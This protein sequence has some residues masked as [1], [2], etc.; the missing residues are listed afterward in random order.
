MPKLLE[1]D[2]PDTSAEDS[3]GG[4]GVPEVGGPGG[5]VPGRPSGDAA[6]G[7]SPESDGDSAAPKDCVPKFRSDLNYRLVKN[8]LK[9]LPDIDTSD[10]GGLGYTG[11]ALQR[12]R[13]A[14]G[15]L[16]RILTRAAEAHSRCKQAFRASRRRLRMEID[17]AMRDPENKEAN[18]RKD[19]SWRTKGERQ[20][21][22]EAQN[23]RMRE[24]VDQLEDW[25][26]QWGAFKEVVEAGLDRVLHYRQDIG[27][28]LKVLALQRGGED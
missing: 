13:E 6:D 5:D 28:Y 18:E 3:G 17:R 22:V 8:I 4:G 9:T 10:A 25:K 21:I 11:L 20:E 27:K 15:L 2:D 14:E 24:E 19:G 7:R 23:F 26:D 1:G 16:T 12:A